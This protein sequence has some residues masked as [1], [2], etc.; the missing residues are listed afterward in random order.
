MGLG[1]GEARGLAGL[2]QRG[3]IVVNRLDRVSVNVEVRV[4]VRVRVKVRVK[5]RVR[6]RIR[7]RVRVR[8]TGAHT[9]G[10]TVRWGPPPHRPNSRRTSTSFS[11]SRTP[12]SASGRRRLTSGH[13]TQCLRLA[14]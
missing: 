7:V 2:D 8:V 3:I 14:P 5:V 10:L 12:P 13:W 6:V 11:G 1:L 4:R 9:R